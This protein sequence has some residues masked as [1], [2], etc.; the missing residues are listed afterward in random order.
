LIGTGTEYPVAN[1]EPRATYYFQVAAVNAVGSSEWSSP[2]RLVKVQQMPPAKM[3]VPHVLQ[4][5]PNSITLGFTPPA[6][7]GTRDGLMVQSYTLHYS[8][9]PSRHALLDAG[10]ER[11]FGVIRNAKPSGVEI[12]GL[13]PGQPVACRILAVNEYGE[14]E[15]SDMADFLADIAPPEAPGRPKLAERTNFSITLSMA[16]GGDSGLEITHFGV[17]VEELT[18]EGVRSGRCWAEPNM[19]VTHSEGGLQYYGV[20][21]LKPGV[22]YCFRGYTVN[23]VGPSP[24]SEASEPLHTEPMAPEP[25][26]KGL[27]VEDVA[28]TSFRFHWERPYQNGS[29]VIGYKVHWTTDEDFRKG[30]QELTTID[31]TALLCNCIPS[32]LH[33]VRVAGINDEGRGHFGPALRVTT[34]AGVPMAPVQAR[35]TASGPINARVGWMLPYECGSPITGLFIRFTETATDGRPA[36]ERDQGEV[37][38]KGRK[39][40][41]SIEPLFSQ[42]EYV[43]Q[44]AAENSIGLGP[45]SEL[46]AP[47]RIGRPQVPMAPSQP[48]IVTSS[49]EE[50]TVSWNASE[51]MGADILEQVVQFCSTPDFAQGP[52]LQFCVPPWSLEQKQASEKHNASTMSTTG[53]SDAHTTA[54]DAQMMHSVMTTSDSWLDV[55]G[56]APGESQ[57]LLGAGSLGPAQHSTREQPSDLTKPVIGGSFMTEISLRRKAASADL[58]RPVLVSLDKSQ[59]AEAFR[60]E[61]VTVQVVKRYEDHEPSG[62]EARLQCQSRHYHPPNMEGEYTFCELTPGTSYARVA[63]RNRVGIGPFS[64]TSAHMATTAAGS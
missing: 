16:L 35:M 21:G 61:V 32:L 62:P 64:P 30:V 13:R 2:S 52:V 10:D 26:E 12:T 48:V 44:V 49:P 60:M 41:C 3:T 1:L 50:L 22:A 17:E 43:F 36:L 40:L 18:V 31:T 6:D 63:S 24:T 46:T 38:I 25:V 4:Q 47:A 8:D 45:W 53:F 20:T 42:R 51:S 54:A 37:Y 11:K 29:D 7:L 28:A 14:G 55:E 33:F 39:R 56:L 5:T 23:G 15:F 58:Q 27:S 57:E 9:G 34:T 59:V 19:P